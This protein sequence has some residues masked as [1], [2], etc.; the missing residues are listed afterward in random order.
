MVLKEA[1][2]SCLEMIE[3]AKSL[4]LSIKAQNGLVQAVADIA[5]QEMREEVSALREKVKRSQV[6]EVA[7]IAPAPQASAEITEVLVEADDGDSD[8]FSDE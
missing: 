5:Q 3:Q 6:E 8:P 2:V 1:K 7:A 4:G